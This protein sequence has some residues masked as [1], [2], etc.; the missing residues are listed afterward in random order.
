[1]GSPVKFRCPYQAMLFGLVIRLPGLLLGT[2]IV[3][4]WIVP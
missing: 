2:D 1:M 3:R 4:L